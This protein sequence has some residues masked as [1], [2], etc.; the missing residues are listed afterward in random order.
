MEPL[1]S[2]STSSWYGLLGIH[3][4]APLLALALDLL[5]GDPPNR[6]HTTVAMGSFI[7]WVE[8]HSPKEGRTR[9]FLFG[10]VMV[11]LGALLAA[12]FA[13][14]V[15]WAARRLPFIVLLMIQV[16]LLKMTFSIRR[17]LQV[18]CEIV[19]AL[20]SGN[21][22]EA[23]HLVSW[24]LVSRNTQEL[25]TEHLASATI[26]SLTESL[27]DSFVSPLF[28]YL[29]GGLPLAWFYRFVNTADS[30]LGYRD[31]RREYLGK[32]AAR[33]DD[34]LNYIPARVAG[35]MVVL[36]ASLA[37]GSTKDA[38]RTMVRQHD[39]TASPASGWTMSAAAGVLGVTLEKVDHYRLEGDDRLPA[40]M[41]IL[42]ARQLVQAAALL[43]VLFCTVILWA[44]VGAGYAG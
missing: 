5:L 11:S 41:D 9:Q 21:L 19:G 34:V 27:T 6:F 44:L 18:A 10:M 15:I 28:M 24:H 2:F 3:L 32:F 42:S 8:R 1:L 13:L 4:F 37:H 43:W 29:L 14:L 17:M 38:W 22:E 36:S 30:I 40:V 31:E 39:R 33:L 23:R 35:I 25:G 26:E 7:F 20:R 12:L 16:V